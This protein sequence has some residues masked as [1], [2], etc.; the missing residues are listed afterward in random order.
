MK[1]IFILILLS[2]PKSSVF[3]QDLILGKPSKEDSSL[4][5]SSWNL[6]IKAVENK[7]I[8]LIK[9]LSLSL[10][11]CEICTANNSWS[12]LDKPGED[13]FIKVDSFANILFNEIA[14]TKIWAVIKS[15]IPATSTRSIKDYYPRSLKIKKG[16]KFTIYELGY[17]TWK[18]DEFAKGHEGASHIFQFV[19]L[20]GFFKL[21]GVTS[22]P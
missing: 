9:T 17:Q 12:S 5:M 4:L 16:T 11:D 18:P 6:Y 2:F 8:K 22:V 20:K 1:Y 21:Y 3:G 15:S 19:K 14:Q 10:I 7:D 13:S